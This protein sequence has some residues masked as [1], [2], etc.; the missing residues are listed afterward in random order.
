MCNNYYYKQHTIVSDKMNWIVSIAETIAMQEAK[1]SD[2]VM[3]EALV[4][5]KSI[6]H[7][8]HD[9]EEIA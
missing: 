5:H 3:V 7:F 8:L 6:V 1:Q 9:A 4:F 2:N